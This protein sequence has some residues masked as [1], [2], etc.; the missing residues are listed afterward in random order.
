MTILLIEDDQALSMGLV[1]ALEEEGYTPLHAETAQAAQR[2]FAE[3]GFDLVLMD[4]MLPDGNG[5]DLC[6]QLR[7]RSNV[8]VIFLTSCDDEV[9]I[10]MGLDTGGDDYVT[11]PC[12]LKELMSRIKAQLR[13]SSTAVTPVV[14]VGDVTLKTEQSQAF[15]EGRELQL[16]VTELRLLTIL[17]RHAGQTMTRAI[18]LDKLWDNKGSFVDDNTLSVH[19]RHL[20]EKLQAAGSR[21][22]IVTVRGIGYRLEG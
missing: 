6:R 21:T 7:K 12:R 2:Y 5:Y 13:R 22:E 19:I 4:V 11:K 18:L 15:V 3:G 9:N 16:T 1:F 10:V 14:S 20:R 17:C 8:P